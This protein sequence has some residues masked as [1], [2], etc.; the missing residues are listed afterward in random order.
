M[1]LKIMEQTFLRELLFLVCF[2]LVGSQIKADTTK[3]VAVVVHQFKIESEYKQLIDS[4]K[5]EPNIYNLIIVLGDIPAYA[6]NKRIYDEII[7]YFIAHGC[8]IHAKC[9]MKTFLDYGVKYSYLNGKFANKTQ[10]E[11][12]ALVK[13]AEEK[14]GSDI[15][16][17]FFIRFKHGIMTYV[18][19]APENPYVVQALIDNGA[20][21]NNLGG[22]LNFF[23]SAKKYDWLIEKNI[24]ELKDLETINLNIAKHIYKNNSYIN[25]A[26]MYVLMSKAMYKKIN[27]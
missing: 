1:G 17:R 20:D 15:L 25:R 13:E 11:I 3:A 10:D 7:K 4:G 21:V 9:D 23:R 27:E 16:T 2:A 19:G 26:I 6:K 8:D 18:A 5:L 24:S 14:L 22:I 12:Q